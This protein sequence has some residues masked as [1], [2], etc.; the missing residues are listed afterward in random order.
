MSWF[1]M[2]LPLV[3][4]PSRCPFKSISASEQVASTEMDRQNP[5]VK[6][7]ICP[8]LV[9]QLCVVSIFVS[10]DPKST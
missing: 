9:L 7:L 5:S 8:L 10:S 3:R 4:Q 2:R 1:G 6:T